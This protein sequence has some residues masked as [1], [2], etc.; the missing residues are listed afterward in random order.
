MKYTITGINVDVTDAMKSKAEEKFVKLQKYF[1]K[2]IEVKA[3]FK[4][5][6][7]DNIVELT[8]PLKGKMLRAEVRDKDMYDAI[9]EAVHI[10]ERQLRKY[11]SRLKDHHKKSGRKLF[12]KAFLEE[13]QEQEE[14]KVERRK[15]IPVKPMSEEEAMLQLE[16]LG[17]NFFVFLNQDT[18]LVNV[19]YKRKKGH[20]GLIEPEL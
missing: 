10:I 2:E 16:L 9:D 19:I 1:S 3:R 14:L 7:L 5:D 8:I 6:N 15:K 11:K 18:N 4:V 17:H 13:D 12:A 20:Y